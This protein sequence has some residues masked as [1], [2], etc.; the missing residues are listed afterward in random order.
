MGMIL[1][2]YAEPFIFRRFSYDLP[3]GQP[4]KYWRVWL[5]KKFPF[6]SNNERVFLA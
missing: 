6:G 5:L 2:F 3:L 4:K 1:R